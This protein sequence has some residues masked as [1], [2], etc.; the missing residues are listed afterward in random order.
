MRTLQHPGTSGNYYTEEAMARVSTYLNFE[1]STE[2]AFNF[3]RSVFGTQFSG[4]IMRFGDIPAQ[5]GQPATPEADRKL[6][7]HI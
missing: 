2:D 6:V 4:P 3:Y 5:P 1:R 7:M